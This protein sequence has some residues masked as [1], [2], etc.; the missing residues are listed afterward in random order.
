MGS[1]KQRLQ[2]RSA[3]HSSVKK[4]RIR[5]GQDAV[6]LHI[7]QYLLLNRQILLTAHISEETERIVYIQTAVA[8]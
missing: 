2:G 7:R 5:K 1:C 8:A 3:G 4:K 6:V